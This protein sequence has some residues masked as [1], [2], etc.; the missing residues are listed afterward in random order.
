M[1]Q[2]HN[3]TSP[4]VTQSLPVARAVYNP[5][6]IDALAGCPEDVR[7]LRAEMQEIR[8]MQTQIMQLL[9]LIMDRLQD[10]AAPQMDASL[11][12]VVTLEILASTPKRENER[13]GPPVRD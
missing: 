13:T 3:P 11:Q 5:A 7:D 4:P 1:S 12:K 8:E 2:V 6:G 9:H 10:R